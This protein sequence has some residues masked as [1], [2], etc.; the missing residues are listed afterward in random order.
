MAHASEIHI[1]VAGSDLRL[2]EVPVAVRY[3]DYSKAKGQSG[4]NSIRIFF[5]LMIHKFSR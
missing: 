3:T 5:D 1:L 2:E 4:W